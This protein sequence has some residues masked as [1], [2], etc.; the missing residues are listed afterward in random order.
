MDLSWTCGELVSLLCL[1]TCSLAYS[2]YFYSHVYKKAT[3]DDIL[4]VVAAGSYI[5]VYAAFLFVLYSRDGKICD[6][7]R[8][9]LLMLMI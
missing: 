8:D 5:A 2:L 4:A 6:S 7:S 3:D 9:L 1:S